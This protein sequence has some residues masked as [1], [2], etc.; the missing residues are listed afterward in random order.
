[1]YSCVDRI[2]MFVCIYFVAY[3]LLL[4]YF[5]CDFSTQPE[6]F[7]GRELALHNILYDV[8]RRRLVTVV[9]AA[10]IGKSAIGT[11]AAHWCAL[12][13]IF[14]GGVIFV[15]V[16]A[17][18]ESASAL[19][20]QQRQ[21]ANMQLQQQQQLYA[22]NTAMKTGG[23]PSPI[24]PR[25]P[26]AGQ[27]PTPGRGGGGA[28]HR[29]KNAP[30]PLFGMGSPSADAADEESPQLGRKHAS[31]HGRRHRGKR[32]DGEGSPAQHQQLQRVRGKAHSNLSPFPHTAAAAADTAGAVDEVDALLSETSAVVFTEQEAVVIALVK[33]VCPDVWEHLHDRFV[34]STT[35]AATSNSIARRGHD[36]VPATHPSLRPPIQHPVLV[37]TAAAI[38]RER[39][40]HHHS[41][42]ATAPSLSHSPVPIGGGAMTPSSSTG[43]LAAIHHRGSRAS[44]PAHLPISSASV[45]AVAA[46]G[47]SGSE[48]AG[49]AL[50]E[51]FGEPN[52]ES[53][54]AAPAVGAAGRLQRQ[55]RGDDG[56]AASASAPATPPL[57]RRPTLE[58]M[59]AIVTD[60]LHAHH[61]LLVLDNVDGS[62]VQP[63]PPTLSTM[64]GVSPLLP[65]SLTVEGTHSSQQLSIPLSNNY[66]YVSLA[67][68]SSQVP[69]DL[70]AQLGSAVHSPWSPQQQQQQQYPSFSAFSPSF[71]GLPWWLPQQPEDLSV[72]FHLQQQQQQQQMT[73][74]VAPLPQQQQQQGFLRGPS[75]SDAP[76]SAAAAAASAL[77]P[78]PR[79]C[80]ASSDWIRGLMSAL[81]NRTLH[82]HVLATAR[83]PL[84]EA[85]RTQPPPSSHY[86]H[87]SGF[88]FS[89]SGTDGGTS[90]SSRPGTPIP[91]LPSSPPFPVFGGSSSGTSAVSEVVHHL[92]AL[93]PADA[94]RLFGLTLGRSVV[95]QG[96]WGLEQALGV[97]VALQCIPGRVIEDAQSRQ[98]GGPG[99]GGGDWESSVIGPTS[100]AMSNLFTHKGSGGA[101]A[102]ATSLVSA[103]SAL[104]SSSSPSNL[105]HGTPSHLTP[106]EVGLS[107][108]GLRG[109]PTSPMNDDEAR[110]GRRHRRRM[111][112][113]RQ[114]GQDVDE[115]EADAP[116]APDSVVLTE[117]SDVPPL[118]VPRQGGGSRH[119]LDRLGSNR[120][121][122]RRLR[123]VHA[124]ETWE[125][126]ARG[127]VFDGPPP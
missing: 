82:V 23:S 61:I 64:A 59:L 14:D 24:I 53:A 108:S 20:G 55:T 58:E 92:P 123:G 116:V 30:R 50:E 41:R 21:R 93:A 54:A 105:G 119:R 22:R 31:R 110:R 12:R 125:T 114:R 107:S 100:A 49:N 15:D 13:R 25:T 27:T 73:M 89:F 52:D 43:E 80:D 19:R 3:A 101:V 115:Q 51:A 97:V 16:R 62:D 5:S 117:Q 18:I 8:I 2:V 69:R 102:L 11:A 99:G 90:G 66:A 26:T 112:R 83:K 124:L 79:E 106:V 17:A 127:D 103:P 60:R 87:P 42:G 94:A 36:D 121:S 45:H 10:G 81:L 91:R 75:S 98:M 85:G 77:A 118:P 86:H 29:S 7:L 32:D 33:A 65:R 6:H 47:D 35:A 68:A 46:A 63:A 28:A 111:E 56:P 67:D 109:T 1:M 126:L 70:D 48:S 38:A 88:G 95:M 84:R 96:G 57:V 120:S 122:R 72:S 34:S 71:G 76:A 104:P 9:G 78:P 4:L 44:L 37:A 39:S 40:H 113:R 74:M